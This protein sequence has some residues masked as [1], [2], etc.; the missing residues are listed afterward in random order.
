VTGAI[1]MRQDPARRIAIVGAGPIGLEAALYARTLGHEPVVYERRQVADNVAAWGFVRLFSPWAMNVTSLGRQ[2]LAEAGKWPSPPPKDA[3][4]TGEELRRAYLLPLAETLESSVRPNVQVLAVG[5]DDYGK[6]EAIGSPQRAN[7]PFR[8]LVRDAG[9]AERIEHADIVLDCSGTYRHHRWAGRG[10]V[11]APGER[12]LEGRIWYTIPD[13]LGRDRDRFAD[14]HTLLIGAGF[15]AA[16][17]L[18]HLEK[19]ASSWPRTRLTWAIR[20][21]G[22]AL[23]AI[24][25]DPLTGRR[26]LVMNSLRLRERPPTWL[27][28]L[29]TCLLEHV[30]ATDRF[31]VTL[32]YMQTDLVMTVDE[33]I[34]M[35]GYRPDES[36]FEQLQVHQCYATGG[37]MKLAAALM[38]ESGGDCLETGSN[39]GIETLINPEP[40]FYILGAK[41]Y[42]TNSNFLLTVGHRQIRDAFKVIEGKP[43]LDL[44][45]S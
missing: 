43:D 6:A 5:R 14:R 44:Y 25:G 22:Q 1:R 21:P 27:Q 23:E 9:G 8:I 41:S 37:P 11:P 19:L 2:A 33:I 20:R 16:T 36:I 13:L 7:S 29:G 28:F 39:L 18:N 17:V 40:N 35:V 3:C 10:G 34:A 24:I 32:R 12:E 15:S 45:R 38:G 4:P 31:E 26:E 30:R 42:G